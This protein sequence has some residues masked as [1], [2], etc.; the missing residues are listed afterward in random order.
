MSEPIYKFNINLLELSKSKEIAIAK[1]EWREIYREKRE[2]KTGL[3]ICQHTLKNIIYMY[4]IFTKH[5]I[6]VGTTCCKKFKL[7]IIKINNI[8]EKV[9]SKM[10]INGEYKIINN[11]L[12]YTNNIKTQLIKYIRNE[13]ENM[14]NLEELK[15]FNN[16]IKILINDYDL[17]YLHDIYDEIMEKI[18][19]EE[20]KEYEKMELEK[21]QIKQM[22]EKKEY[23]KLELDKLKFC[24]SRCNNNLEN[25]NIIK[26]NEEITKKGVL[27]ACKTCSLLIN[28]WL[29]RGYKEKSF[30]Y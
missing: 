4:N 7:Q 21:S 20:K 23:E 15:K 19:N 14:R 2:E 29:D 1:I 10:L 13:Y 28:N 24:C 5:T 22:Q 25:D 26:Y 16:D 30:I 17:T 11:I 8:L 3:C 18:I 9:I 27:F 12:E 6:S